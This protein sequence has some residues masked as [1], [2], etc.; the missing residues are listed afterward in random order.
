MLFIYSS[1]HPRR[2]MSVRACDRSKCGD[3]TRAT[4]TRS[5]VP[6]T[7]TLPSP[8]SRRTVRAAPTVAELARARAANARPVGSSK[9]AH[10]TRLV[11][12]AYVAW[13]LKALPLTSA[14]S[15]LP[16]LAPSATWSASPFLTAPSPAVEPAPSP[17]EPSRVFISSRP[18][19][20]SRSLV[21]ATSLR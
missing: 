7:G 2:L 8:T 5:G 11:D 20:T 3:A 12:F 21:L 9:F 13:L 15:H 14:S 10:T 19:N 1:F 16:P 18:P 6:G 4:R 17:T